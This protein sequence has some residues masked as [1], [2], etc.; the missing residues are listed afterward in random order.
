MTYNVYISLYLS[1]YIDISIYLSIHPSIYTRRGKPGIIDSH[2]TCPKAFPST[3]VKE[4]AQQE[5]KAEG[6]SG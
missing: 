3:E 6:D 4:V 5:K 2:V 1:V